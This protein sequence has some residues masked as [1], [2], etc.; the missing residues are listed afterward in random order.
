MSIICV[1]YYEA[2]ERHSKFISPSGDGFV[3]VYQL[4][5]DSKGGKEELRKT[6][7]KNLDEEIQAYRES[8]DITNIIN[9]FVN[10]ETD[11]LHQ[12]D[13]AYV[14]ATDAPKSYAEYFAR[15]KEAEKIFNQLPSDIKDR[16]DNDPEKFFLEFGTDSFV[17]KVSDLDDPNTEVNEPMNVVKEAFDNAE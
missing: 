5:K 16:F 2:M 1:S 13:G 12:V 17:N 14:D 11:V 15:V 8:T 6:G 7:R 10:G 3:D 4:E 9:R